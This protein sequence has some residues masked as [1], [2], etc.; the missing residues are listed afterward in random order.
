MC[1]AGQ[2]VSLTIT[3]PGPSFLFSYDIVISR[4]ARAFRLKKFLIR[5]TKG[6][7]TS[8]KAISVSIEKNM[9]T[10]TSVLVLGRKGYFSLQFLL[11]QFL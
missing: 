2:R 3:G 10:L 1:T 11:L 7:H 8:K 9:S 5:T 6:R 4:R